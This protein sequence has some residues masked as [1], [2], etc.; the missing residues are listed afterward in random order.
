MVEI[1]IWGEE[2]EKKNK[3]K[4]VNYFFKIEIYYLKIIEKQMFFS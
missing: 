3:N 4:N 1:G 2:F